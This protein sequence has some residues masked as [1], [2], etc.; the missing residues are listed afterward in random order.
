[1]KSPWEEN[2][3]NLKNELGSVR[4]QASA[5]IKDIES[6]MR[7]MEWI[8]PAYVLKR[9]GYQREVIERMR[10]FGVVWH[11][12]QVRRLS[13]LI[14][15]GSA[16]IGGL[17][18]RDPVMAL[19]AGMS[20]FDGLIRGLGGTRWY[21][22]LDERLLVVSEDEAKP[23]MNCAPW[24]SVTLELEELKK[25]ALTGEKIGNLDSIVE[26]LREEAPRLPKAYRLP[27]RV[28][29]KSSQKPH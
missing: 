23:R 8:K 25:K 16:A 19:N 12:E 14:G 4:E 6:L 26:K 9:L 18:S 22:S 15:L 13:W 20:G 5:L 1:M 28:Y 17:V 11:Y 2:L 3:S 27:R 29:N 7:E 10:G 24:E 21:V